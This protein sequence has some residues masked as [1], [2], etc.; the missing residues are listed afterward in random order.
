MKV[1]HFAGSY[2]VGIS[3]LTVQAT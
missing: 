3:Q 2:D 1:V